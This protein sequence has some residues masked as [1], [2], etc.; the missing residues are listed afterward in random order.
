MAA[1]AERLEAVFNSLVNG[2]DLLRYDNSAQPTKAKLLPRYLLKYTNLVLALNE[3]GWG[4]LRGD[5]LKATTA[6]AQDLRA[7]GK[8]KSDS[9]M[10]DWVEVNCRR[11]LNVTWHAPQAILKAKAQ[12]TSGAPWLPKL[13]LSPVALTKPASREK[14]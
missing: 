9:H 10:T 8:T 11:V 12:G 14:A 13:G 1:P 4:Y 3:M 2:T 5:V 6:I 7:Q